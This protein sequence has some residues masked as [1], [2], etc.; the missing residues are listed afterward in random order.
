[1]PQRSFLRDVTSVLS[2]NIFAVI[3]GLLVSIILSRS[4]GPE[5]YG[6]YSAILVVP[7]LVMSII[8]MGVR[9][10]A[11]YYMGNKQYDQDKVVSNILI[12]LGI[13][14][15]LGI[16]VS[17]L[18]FMVLNDENFTILL[19][20]L[21]VLI[22][23]SRLANMY[24]GGIFIGKEQISR[25][26]LFVWLTVLLNLVAVVIFVVL[27]KM[28]VAGALISVLV[29]GYI[30]TFV[31]FRIIFREYSVRLKPDREVIKKILGMGALFAMAFAV[32]QLN[33]RID[34]LI[35]DRMAGEAEVGYYSLAVSISEKLWQLP[36]AV[37][38]VL[39]SR[40]AN[41][42]DQQLINRQTARLLRVSMIAIVL[43]VILLYFIAPFIVP[44]IWGSDFEPSVQLLQYILPGILFMSIYRI[45]SSRLSGIGMPHISIYV[46]LPALILNI[47]LNWWWIPL[48]GAM[49]AVLATNVS[50]TWASV[51]Y[52][53]VYARI[54]K[55]PVK[56][57]FRYQRSDF[58][59]IGVLVNR[60][61][62]R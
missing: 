42:T 2:S 61:R 23:P 46:F 28:D 6:I 52:L 38:V 9:G 57:I 34:I 49:G 26:Y 13:T 43:A 20:L 7:M 45:I 58:E 11:I 33:Y 18:T 30:V 3:N 35:L 59:F 8:Q 39:M 50:Y 60:I 12:L 24:I 29:S 41:A 40:T 14:S 19:I 37:G 48:Q 16:L 36:L 15:T 47:V 25:A 31:V 44:L 62:K 54:V 10:S 1:M 17:L 5:G 27:L 51:I 21:V 22:I 32:I 55:M 53:F 4:L 56:E